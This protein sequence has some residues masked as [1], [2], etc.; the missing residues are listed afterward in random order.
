V[1]TVGS[2]LPLVY[3]LMPFLSVRS[4]DKEYQVFFYRCSVHSEIYIVHSQKKKK[5]T[6]Y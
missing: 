4:A 2:I 1:E 6:I 3:K 5:C